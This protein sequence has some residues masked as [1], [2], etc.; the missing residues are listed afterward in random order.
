LL[1]RGYKYFPAKVPLFSRGGR[2]L[3]PM[4]YF[5]RPYLK[6]PLIPYNSKRRKRKKIKWPPGVHWIKHGL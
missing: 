1:Y 2:Q 3:A 5:F 4:T 6:N